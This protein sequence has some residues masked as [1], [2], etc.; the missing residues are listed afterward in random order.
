MPPARNA[1][2]AVPDYSI[3]IPAF[4]EEKLLPDTL[5]ALAAAMAALPQLAGE[6]IVTDNDSADRTAAVAAL[7]GVRVVFE[8]HRQIARARNAGA[9]AARGRYLVF[10]DADTRVSPALLG[11]TLRVLESDA[12]C[13]G[14]ATVVFDG[15][16]TLAAALSARL[17]NLLSRLCRWAAGSYIFCRREAFV[18]IGGFDERFYASEELHFSRAMKH[19]G[20]RDGCGFIILDEPVVTSSRKLDWFGAGRMARYAVRLALRPGMLRRREG[21]GPW[22]ERPPKS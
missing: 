1:L 19:W 3:V 10:V 6:V 16:L 22:Y 14:G 5:A 2:P 13:G 4:N 18:G 21:C 12:F 15:R 8:K 9:A 11:R 7:H 17:W 20:R